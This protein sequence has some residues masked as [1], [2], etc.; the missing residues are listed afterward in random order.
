ML[1]NEE[2]KPDHPLSNTVPADICDSFKAGGC[3]GVRNK[4]SFNVILQYKTKLNK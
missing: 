4:Y 1:L 3:Y 2:T